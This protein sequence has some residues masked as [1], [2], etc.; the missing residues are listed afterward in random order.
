MANTL[1]CERLYRSIYRL[2]VLRMMA[3]LWLRILWRGQ[4]FHLFF[5]SA[6]VKFAYKKS[7]SFILWI[8]G[9]IFLHSSCLNSKLGCVWYWIFFVF[10]GC[11]FTLFYAVVTVVTEMV[12]YLRLIFGSVDTACMECAACVHILGSC[13]T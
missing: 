11:C 6:D 2:W 3:F 8:Q 12:I 1:E 9:M 13:R 5:I 10:V 7:L 4:K